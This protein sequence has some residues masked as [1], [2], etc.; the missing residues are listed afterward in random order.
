MTTAH[1]FLKTASA[2]YLLALAA[3]CLPGGNRL[4]FRLLLPLALLCNAASVG[5]RYWNAWPMPPMYLGPAALPLGLG[6]PALFFRERAESASPLRSV[7]FRLLALTFFLALL[8]TLFP[9]DFYLPFLKSR[10]LLAHGF[11]LFG[12]AGKV[13]FLTAAVSWDGEK[14]RRG[15]AE[16]GSG[17]SP[18]SPSSPR[19]V[20]PSPRLPLLLVW[21]FAF[22]TLSMFSG[23]LWAY[24]GWGT[25]VVW[26]D[27]I[28]ATTMA[29]WFFYGGL[30]HLHLTRI[31]TAPRRAAAT[32]FGGLLVVGLTVVPEL[33]PFRPPF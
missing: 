21:G 13:C 9:K 23:E 15:D 12:L 25:P 33:G 11:L 26:D 32:A 19:R 18:L 10:T 29:T 1:V 31:G 28:I 8:A 3:T 24:R 4:P 14:W 5:I 30:L 2:L 16:N 7:R 22:W 27:P 17:A 6:L 20:S